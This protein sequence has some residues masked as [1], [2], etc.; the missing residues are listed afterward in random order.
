MSKTPR[1][2]AALHSV[3]AVFEALL[4]SATTKVTAAEAQAIQTLIVVL[5][6]CSRRLELDLAAGQKRKTKLKESKK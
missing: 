3:A 2:D 5:V 1:T 4:D 6:D